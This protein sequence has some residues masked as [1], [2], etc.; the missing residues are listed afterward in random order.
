VVT[1]A[2]LPVIVAL[3]AVFL[4]WK[5]LKGMAK[6]VA[7]LVILVLAAVYVFGVQH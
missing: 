4:V 2:I 5:L 7:L 1:S 3:I 6:T